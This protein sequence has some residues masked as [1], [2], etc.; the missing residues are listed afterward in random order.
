MQNNIKALAEAEVV[1]HDFCCTSRMHGKKELAG[2][3]K[4]TECTTQLHKVSS[5]Y[6][7]R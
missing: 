7:T 2:Q 3:A 4:V 1:L 5:H 6:R